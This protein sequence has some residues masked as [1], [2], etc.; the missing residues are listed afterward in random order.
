M[1]KLELTLTLPNPNPMTDKE[2]I[3]DYFLI[4]RD[5][6]RKILIMNQN[7]KMGVLVGVAVSISLSD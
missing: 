4:P 1:L 5:R 2:V 6:I 7:I 3:V